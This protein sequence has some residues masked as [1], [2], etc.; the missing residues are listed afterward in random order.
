[1]QN[2]ESVQDKLVIQTRALSK[3]FRNTDVRKELANNS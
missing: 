3:R 2:L 1:M